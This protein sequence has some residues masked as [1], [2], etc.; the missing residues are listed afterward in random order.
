MSF[1]VAFRN[2]LPL[3]LGSI[4]TLGVFKGA[5]TPSGFSVLASDDTPYSVS[6]TVLD[7]A[8]TSYTVSSSVLDSAGNSYNPI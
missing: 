1:G 8:D 5:S 6:L 2:G 3:G 4:A 7:S